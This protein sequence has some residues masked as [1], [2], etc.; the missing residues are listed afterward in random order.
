MAMNLSNHLKAIIYPGNI[1]TEDVCGIHKDKCF[2]VLHFNYECCKERDKAGFPYGKTT[3]TFLD[4]TLR[5]M[6]P[7][8]GKMFYQQ[9]HRNEPC[10]YT[11]MFNVKF[12]QH[13]LDSLIKESEDDMVVSGYVVDVEDDYTTTPLGDG[14][15]EQMQ[16]HVKLLVANMTYIGTNGNR[17]IDISRSNQ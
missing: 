3:S 10:D 16:I 11:F 4:F 7:E 8:D 6:S 1:L 2:T 9:M 12:K 14:T 17:S 15:T 13:L 5:L